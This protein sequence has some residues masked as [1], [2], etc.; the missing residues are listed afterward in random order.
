[1]S[2]RARSH[3]TPVPSWLQTLIAA[4][5]LLALVAIVAKILSDRRTE[6][7]ALIREGSDLVTHARELVKTQLGPAAIMFGSDEEADARLHAT[8]EEWWTGMRSSLLAYGN[9]HPSEGVRRLTEELAVAVGDAFGATW[10]LLRARR[11][12]TTMDSF[13]RAEE[14]SGAAV[15]K[16]DELMDAIRKRRLPSWL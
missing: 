9:R 11:F 1:M 5:L 2:L 8:R 15:A 6:H 4:P 14:A 12:E 7:A 16:A 13:H 10:G 3:D